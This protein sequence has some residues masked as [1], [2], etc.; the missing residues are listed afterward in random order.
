MKGARA[1]FWAVLA[2]AA[3][4]AGA[5]H[6][7][8]ACV[9]A[10]FE[11]AASVWMLA[12]P[13][14]LSA[15]LL[16]AQLAVTA[17]DVEQGER[18]V[19]GALLSTPAAALHPVVLAAATVIS[20]V[21]SSSPRP[22]RPPMP[23]TP[24]PAGMPLTE[25]A[26]AIGRAIGWV[27]RLLTSD[28]SA[29]PVGAAAEAD[30]IAYARGG[31][32][33]FQHLAACTGFGGYI[34]T[35]PPI[36]FDVVLGFFFAARAGHAPRALAY[37]RVLAA[38]IRAVPAQ[39]YDRIALILADRLQPVLSRG[40]EVAAADDLAEILRA[41]RLVGPGLA[42]WEVAASAAA[43]ASASA[44]ATAARAAGGGGGE[45]G[46]GGGGEECGGGGGG[47]ELEERWRW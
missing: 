12:S 20:A 8:R 36:V 13:H 14:M 39:A 5:P 17:G 15:L 32:V 11:A 27:Q 34:M 6:A 25:Y 4:S 3:Q 33:A 35:R 21:L 22:P 40:G 9:D 19:A 16:L 43:A 28:F 18:L 1:C 2:I 29:V 31:L 26:A 7:A 41:S 30:A 38:G 42:E 46:G 23:P 45:G 47:G 24:R 10:A 37:A 44:A